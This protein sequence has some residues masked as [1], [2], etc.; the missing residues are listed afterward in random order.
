MK[1]PIKILHI[2]ADCQVVYII[3]LDGVQIKSPLP[4]ETAIFMLENEKFDLI[5]SEPQ[6][7]AVLTP[8]TGMAKLE[9]IINSLLK[10][11]GSMPSFIIH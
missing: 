11:P 5:F 7:M 8:Q 9:S 10:N 1:V 4:L 3:I 6:N 2:K